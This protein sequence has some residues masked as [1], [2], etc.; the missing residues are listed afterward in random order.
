M[1][2]VFPIRYVSSIATAGQSGGAGATVNGAP[3]RD[4][5]AQCGKKPDGGAKALKVCSGCKM[6]WYCSR[7][8]QVRM[9]AYSTA[10]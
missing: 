7:D 6:I 4:M 9:P 10:V 1:H 2:A 5:C 8:C 3:G